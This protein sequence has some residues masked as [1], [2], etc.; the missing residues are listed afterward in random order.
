MDVMYHFSKYVLIAW[1]NKVHCIDNSIMAAF[2]KLAFSE[3]YRQL[4]NC[5]LGVNKVF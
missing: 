4:L 2:I 1:Q 5:L 3:F